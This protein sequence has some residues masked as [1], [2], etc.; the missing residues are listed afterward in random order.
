MIKIAYFLVFLLCN[1]GII[2]FMRYLIRLSLLL[3]L[4]LNIFFAQSAVVMGTKGEVF[5][6]RQDGTLTKAETR[7]YIEE[8]DRIKLEQ[9]SYIALL[10]LK[11]QKAV[12]VR[13]P[14]T[15][16]PKQLF[17]SSLSKYGYG[18]ETTSESMYA[19]ANYVLNQA[20]AS[21]AGRSSGRTLGAVT[22]HTMAPIPLTPRQ[23]YFFADE[24]ILSWRNMPSDEGFLVVIYD[25]E[26]HK[27]YEQEVPSGQ[28]EVT[29]NLSERLKPDV[30]YYFQVSNKRFKSLF[31]ESVVFYVLPKEKEIALRAQEQ[32]FLKD[33]N[34]ESALD[35]ILLG[36]FYEEKGLYAY[37][38]RAY[39]KANELEPGCD[40]YVML[41]NNLQDR[42]RE[43]E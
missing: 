35:M 10:S 18:R 14:G 33:I 36:G 39:K 12:E 27:V 9:K 31:S 19:S 38:M 34:P 37:A 17:A 21:G 11:N 2:I 8:N 4:N 28:N 41:L 43:K 7:M 3:A 24:V 20:M 40:A 23:T 30:P 25:Y 42:I 32:D 26:G 13:Q 22:R 5:V 6:Q 16:T 1:F 29:L 15:Y